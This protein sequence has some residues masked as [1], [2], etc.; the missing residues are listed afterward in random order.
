MPAMGSAITFVA[1]AIVAWL[2]W[3]LL[4]HQESRDT[5]FQRRLEADD[6]RARANRQAAARP[7]EPSDPPSNET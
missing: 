4:A 5:G 2:L 6:R 1:M 3:R 7:P